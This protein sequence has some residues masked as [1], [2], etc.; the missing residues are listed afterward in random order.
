MSDHSGL[1][2]DPGPLRGGPSCWTASDDFDA[3]VAARGATL[4][5]VARGMLRDP[6]H[7]EDVVQDVLVK[8]H[9]HWATILRQDVPDAYVRR[10]LANAC[11]SFWRRAARREH[12]VSGQAMGR[13]TQSWTAPDVP[14][15]VD[16]REV[17][18]A[19]LRRLPAKRRAVLVLRH[20]EGLPD[21]EVAALTGT[22]VQTV[23]SNVHRGLAGLRRML[24]ELEETAP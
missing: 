8:V 4:V 22:S 15:Q 19:L 20:Y 23:R 14:G 2:V 24:T 11:I 10:M 13:V 12:A 6:H 1:A 3:F 21:A 7:A 9:R 17:M 5:R 16:D 18:L